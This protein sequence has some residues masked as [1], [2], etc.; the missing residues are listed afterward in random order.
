MIMPGLLGA[1]E[2]TLFAILLPAPVSIPIIPINEYQLI[3][4]RQAPVS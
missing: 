1:G 3:P 2:E 4:S